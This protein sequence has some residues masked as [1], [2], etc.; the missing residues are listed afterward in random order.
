MTQTPP[1]GIAGNAPRSGLRI[2]KL[3][4]R[5]PGGIGTKVSSY[6]DDLAGG[7]E[8]CFVTGTA[9]VQVAGKDEVAV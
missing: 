8:S 3:C 1:K 5:Q 4:I 2:E 7:Q 6:Y 9:R